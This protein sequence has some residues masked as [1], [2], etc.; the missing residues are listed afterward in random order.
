MKILISLMSVLALTGCGGSEYFSEPSTDLSQCIVGTWQETGSLN[1]DESNLITY[2]ADGTYFNEFTRDYGSNA[3]TYLFNQFVAFL[4]GVPAEESFRYVVNLEGGK[5]EVKGNLL[6]H[7]DVVGTDLTG[8]DFDYMY[9]EAYRIFENAEEISNAPKRMLS[10]HCDNQFS[11]IKDIR[12]LQRSDDNPLTYTSRYEYLNDSGTVTRYEDRI[13]VLNDDGTATYQSTTTRL[14]TPN[15]DFNKIENF[16]YRYSNDLIILTPCT[17]SAS[18][19]NPGLDGTTFFN[20]D[21]VVTESQYY[22][23]R[24]N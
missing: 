9:A 3:Q 23:R 21:F 15:S 7:Y 11:T 10:T 12:A 14:D 24:V 4:F 6:R 18:C 2:N 19:P 16:T 22:F 13:L 5:W 8:N 17:E 1:Y 20:K